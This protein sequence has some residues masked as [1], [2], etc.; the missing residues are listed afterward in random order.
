M[1][2]APEDAYNPI[3]SAAV[4]LGIPL[5]VAVRLLPALRV[6]GLALS[7]ATTVTVKELL[8]HSTVVVTMRYA[9]TNDE[10]KASAVDAINSYIPVTVTPK[11][12]RTRQ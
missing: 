12:R 10:A 4:G 8:G 2:G 11:P 6:V 5:Q 3:Q 7:V 1:L 9:H